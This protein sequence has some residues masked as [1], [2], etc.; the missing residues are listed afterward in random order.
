MN[1]LRYETPHGIHVTRTVTWVPF[2]RGLRSLLQDLDEYQGI[3]LSSGYEYPERY[4]RWD[5]AAIRPPL[6]IVARGREVEFRALN[7]RG[8]VLCQMLLPILAEHTT[9]SAW[10][11]LR[12][13]WPDD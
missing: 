10:L 13:A 3:Y 2:D 11:P 12:T 1:Q 4:S 9:G 5:I 7:G 8:Q 6:A